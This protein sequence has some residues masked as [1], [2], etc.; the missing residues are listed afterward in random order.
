MNCR[1]F[2]NEFEE[3]NA[4]SQRATLHLNDCPDCQKMSS[5]QTY[6]WQMIDALNQV[7]APNNFDF[8]V[9]AR[10]ANTRPKDFQATRFLPAL[11]YVLPTAIIILLVGFIAFNS[12]YF[13]SSQSGGQI[14][15][16]NTSMPIT[17]NDFSA[18]PSDE[19]QIA[20]T[21]A[22]P[23]A[24]ENSKANVPP[25]NVK[26]TSVTKQTDFLAVKSF[27]KSLPRTAQDKGK[28]IKE[29]SI[30]ISV[31]PP[32]KVYLPQGFD[33][34]KT[35]N[36]AMPISVEQIGEFLG[37]EIILENGNRKVRAVRQNSS[38]ARSGVKVGDVIEELNGVKF[39]DESLRAKTI[40][41]KTLTVVRGTEKIEIVLQ[42]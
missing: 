29:G 25:A 20:A 13:S 8:R 28:K 5:R 36:D 23:S 39:S 7:N 14:A 10:I 18:R 38:A 33:Q 24:G 22:P 41:A 4:L 42:K 34:T 2:T 9:K 26:P 15:V 3:R 12:S 32:K 31:T 40:E 30:D 6:V 27:P 16:T 11:R 1:E 19:S 37:I 21:N 35:N 17:K